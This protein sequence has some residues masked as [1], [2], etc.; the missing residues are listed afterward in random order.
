M[1][2]NFPH[3][4]KSESFPE[5]PVNMLGLVD[6]FDVPPS[7]KSIIQ[8]SILNNSTNSSSIIFINNETNI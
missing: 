3:A 6:T 1:E 2:E 5:T 7:E 4:N 8:D